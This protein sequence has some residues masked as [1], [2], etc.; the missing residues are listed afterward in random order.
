MESVLEG[1]LRLITLPSTHPFSSFSWIR[2]SERMLCARLPSHFQHPILLT[3]PVYYHLTPSVFSHTIPLPT[4]HTFR[5][6]LSAF[7]QVDKAACILTY[8]PTLRFQHIR[9]T[10]QSFLTYESDYRP[11]HI[12][13]YSFN[14]YKLL[15]ADSITCDNGKTLSNLTILS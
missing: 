10:F 12:L 14:Y 2:V 7:S 3:R 5:R 8:N 4:K 11:I 1:A 13:K 9:G 15:I 6:S